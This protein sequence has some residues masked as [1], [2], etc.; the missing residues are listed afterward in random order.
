MAFTLFV[1]DLAG[2]VRLARTTALYSPMGYAPAAIVTTNGAVLTIDSAIPAA[3]SNLLR[4]SD[5]TAYLAPFVWQNRI[6][7]IEVSEEGD[8]D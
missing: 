1:V 5:G 6:D 7:T 4:A 2:N 3:Q 8:S